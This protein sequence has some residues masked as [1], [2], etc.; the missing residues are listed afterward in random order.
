MTGNAVAR[1]G[2]IQIS[3][4]SRYS[5]MCSWHTVVRSH[6]PCGS[7]FT[8]IPHDPQIPSRQS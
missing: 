7:P 4:P 3:W 6:G 1:Q 8:I 2:S 5:R